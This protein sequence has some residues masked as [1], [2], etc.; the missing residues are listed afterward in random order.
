MSNNFKP[1]IL[2][3]PKDKQGCGF[4]RMLMPANYL[5]KAGI[6]N[7]EVSYDVM[8][9]QLAEWA[10]IIVLQRPSSY[11]MAEFI[12]YWK[13]NGKRVI[14]EID[15]FMQGILPDN[16][17]KTFWESVGGMTTR[18]MHCMSL[19]DAVTVSTPRLQ[20]EY[21]FYN[22][23][24]HTL[25]N[26]IDRE[27]WEKPLKNKKFYEERRDDDIIR[28]GWEGCVGHRQDLELVAKV[29][30]DLIIEYKGK[31]HLVMMGFTPLDVFL[32]L[33][34]M[35]QNCPE[36]KHSGPLEYYPT[37]P[38]LEYATRL[39][40]LAFDIGIAPT[41]SVSFNDAKSDLR[42]KEYSM[43]GIPTVASDVPAYNESIK[44]NTTGILCKDSYNAWYKALKL[45]IDNEQKRKEMGKNAKIWAETNLMEDNI[46]KWAQVYNKVFGE[47]V[48]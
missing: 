45:L 14:F 37:V 8:N 27:L 21:S 38:L 32:K 18:A 7:A 43:L 26:Y 25:P 15:D 19:C 30:E 3:I 22:R 9:K 28:I 29:L 41:V 20:R 34:N 46:I 23:K 33:P 11:Q 4:Y 42:F 31:V 47:V 6:A 2:L 13:A 44:H 35:H 12:Q 17:G 36:C 5:N 24:I 40:E 48:N 10:N 1:N 39:R 16:P